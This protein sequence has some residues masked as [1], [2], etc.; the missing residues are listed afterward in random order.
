MMMD[1]EVDYLNKVTIC[2]LLYFN[3]ANHAYSP[4]HWK[5]KKTNTCSHKILPLFG[6]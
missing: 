6:V 4:I 1:G 2:F 3:N 5:S